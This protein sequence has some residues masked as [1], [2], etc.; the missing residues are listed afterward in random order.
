MRHRR[1]ASKRGKRRA[2]PGENWNKVVEILA[3]SA[4]EQVKNDPRAAEK[5]RDELLNEAVRRTLELEDYLIE[6]F[7]GHKIPRLPGPWYSRRND[8]RREVQTRLLRGHTYRQIARDLNIALSTVVSDAK[9]QIS[10]QPI[11]NNKLI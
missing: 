2:S 1:R 6:N 8:R 3:Q 9:A 5:D 11:G 10:I 7:G 4:L